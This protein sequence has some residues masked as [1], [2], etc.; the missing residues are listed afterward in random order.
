MSLATRC[1]ACGTV[2]RVVQDQLKVSEGWVRCGRCQEVFNALEG[3]FDLERDAAPPP[4]PEA[5]PEAAPE[6]SPIGESVS[7]RVPLDPAP[8]SAAAAADETP[9]PA[10]L[11]D[12]PQ[13]QVDPLIESRLS[14]Q[15]D[16]DSA[17]AARSSGADPDE[18]DTIGDF[19]D[20]RF[21]TSLLAADAAAN[22]EAPQYGDDRTEDSLDDEVPAAAPAPSFVTEADR[23]ARWHR[24]GVRII[25][26]LA[27]AALLG[28]LGLQVAL[29][30]HDSIAARWPAWRGPL[31]ALCEAAGCVLAPPR[32]LD[33]VAVDSSGLLR[34]S[35]NADAYR[36]SV[37]LRNRAE[38]AV[39]APSI[40]L[41]LTDA[42][43]QMV[44][45]R[46]FEPSDFQSAPRS[47]VPLGETPLQLVLASGER[48]SGYSI[49]I[50]YP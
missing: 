9:V 12:S 27:G 7:G 47:L 22:D 42:S 5:A 19:A 48:I 37:V 36:L 39:A 21:N 41:S 49:E 20:A 33:A 35:D 8:A 2:F 3:L 23:A 1:T 28:L 43:G 4:P 44:A 18:I 11:P 46:V 14:S 6:P 15:I 16:I 17:D 40:E 45:R 50:F 31:A 38:F 26:M 25:T 30:F 10:P 13:V 32:R 29:Q 24:P 34:V